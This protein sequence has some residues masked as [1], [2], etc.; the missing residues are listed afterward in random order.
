MNSSRNRFFVLFLMA[1]LQC[2]APLLHA[3]AHGV[4]VEGKVHM[5][6]EGKA[7]MLASL[8]REH[9]ELPSFVAERDEAP[10]IAMAQEFRHDSSIALSDPPQLA[11]PVSFLE[12]SLV[13]PVQAE[14]VCTASPEDR[15]SY[16]SP[17]P[18]APPSIL[19]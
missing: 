13:R 11:L 2:F 7:A 4:S 18:Q 6:G 14:P 3:H 8:H 1:L 17:F 10:V 9:P 5:H 12:F 19:I 16:L 15:C